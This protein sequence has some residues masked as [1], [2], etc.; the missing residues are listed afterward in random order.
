MKRLGQAV[1]LGS[2]L[3]GLA[4]CQT[5]EPWQKG[6]LADYSMRSDRD[7]LESVMSA[8]VTFSREASTGGEGVGGGGCGCN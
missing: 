6:N 8:H 2:L 4:G 5:V 3:L 1:F 7:Q